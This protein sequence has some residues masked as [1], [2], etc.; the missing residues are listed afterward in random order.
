MRA[1]RPRWLLRCA[2]W[3]FAA[4][5]LA[6]PCLA[7][8]PDAALI[9]RGRY[10]VTAGDC[11]ACHTVDPSRPMAGGYP[12]ATPFGTIYASNI[13]P[14]RAT[15]IGAWTDRD[16]VRAMRRGIG[17]SGRNL[18]PAFPYDSYTLLSRAD[19]LAMKAYLF[20]LP[21][22]HDVIPADH[23]GFPFNQRWL[24]SGWKL[25]NLKDARFRPDPHRSAAWNRGAYLVTALEHCGAC[26]TPR[27]LTMG[28]ET[29]RGLSG[30]MAGTW[31]AY[32]IT[33]SRIHGI[34]A[35]H[36]RDLRDY[37]AT[38]IAPGMAWAAGPMAEAVQDSLSR[39]RPADLDA[40][41]TYLHSL[42]PRT[43]GGGERPRSAYGAPAT[44]EAIRRGRSGVTANAAGARGAALFSGNCASCHGASGTGS[45][46]GYFPPLPHDTSVGAPNANNLV[47]VILTGVQRRTPAGAVFMP[48]FATL[49]NRQVARLASYV[50]RQFGD[51]AVH[52]TPGRVA[53][54]R[55]GMGP[56]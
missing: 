42:R 50:E 27:G 46:D 43:G 36:R 12:V 23:L 49:N 1:P 30:G 28:M 34:G 47:M 45:T 20:S 31:T 56:P 10:L 33:P 35:W 37:L 53:T 38:G 32:N 55:H 5:S 8:A 18:Y 41:V 13:T 26:H 24:L 15:G 48:G 2:L 4:C 44:D 51:P 9:A 16:F 17:R 11:Q 3:A 19:I 39:L 21:P 6:T 14:D 29:S 25:L 54:L 7:A 22:V 52:V 40:I